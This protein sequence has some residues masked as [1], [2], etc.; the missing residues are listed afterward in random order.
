MIARTWRGRV[1]PSDADTYVD[2]L[3]RTGFI[4]LR[5]TTGNLAVLGLRRLT[6]AG[7]EFLLIS[8]WE[9][10]AAIRRF[11]GEH[12]E[13]A[14][15]YPEDSG[16]LVERDEHVDHFDV[17]HVSGPAANGEPA[18]A[19][20]LLRRL[21]EWW[22]GNSSTA[23]AWRARAVANVTPHGFTYVRLP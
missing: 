22:L 20:H 6:P 16:F 17:V 1:R 13:R 5:S 11:A 19:R 8:L 18:R 2:Y 12:P 15:F 3:E 14:V 9:S 4:G 23:L 10:E 7:A 21:A